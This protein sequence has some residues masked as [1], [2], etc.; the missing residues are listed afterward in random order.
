MEL[1]QPGPHRPGH[2]HPLHRHQALPCPPVSATTQTLVYSPRWPCC[3]TYSTRFPVVRN[4][5][6][7]QQ[8]TAPC[9]H[10]V[11]CLPLGRHG[12]AL[13]PSHLGLKNVVLDQASPAAFLPSPRPPEQ[14]PQQK[15]SQPQTE[16]LSA[17]PQD[18]HR[19]TSCPGM[20]PDPQRA[21]G[22]DSPGVSISRTACHPGPQPKHVGLG[23]TG[24][25][26]PWGAR[27]QVCLLR[28]RGPSQHP[29]N[30]V[31]ER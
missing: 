26:G 22:S 6:G 31:R 11:L 14:G 29:E 13:P 30:Q 3:R 12:L 25:P 18:Q 17:G 1:Q 9:S 15:M 10:P 2:Q 7:L 28:D 16:L 19:C 24:S 5:P 20:S 27:S 8:A 4:A 21:R 23:P